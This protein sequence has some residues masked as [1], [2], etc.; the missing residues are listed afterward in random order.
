MKAFVIPRVA[1]IGAEMAAAAESQ[2]A[3][4]Y[5]GLPGVGK[6]LFLQQ[7]TLMATAAGR[8]VHLLQ[9]DVARAGFESEALLAQYPETDGVTHPMIRKAAGLWSRRAVARWHEEFFG[10]EHLLIG[11]VPI[12]GNRFVEL[13]QIHDDCRRTA[14][15]QRGGFVFYTGARK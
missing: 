9:W 11:E 15:G 2:R 7:Q 5:S 8:Q 4:F 6:S 12:I 3:I 13:A 10:P 1:G 14:A